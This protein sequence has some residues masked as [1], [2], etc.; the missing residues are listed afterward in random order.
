MKTI[1]S[2]YLYCSFAGSYHIPCIIL[3]ESKR[4][5]YIEYYDF[6]SKENIKKNV[7]K[8]YVNVLKKKRSK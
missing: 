3:K 2:E 8:S 5:Y 4:K 6:I 1:K 7:D